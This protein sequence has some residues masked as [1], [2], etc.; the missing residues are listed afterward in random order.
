M[1][2]L[3]FKSEGNKT[4]ISEEK[5]THQLVSRLLQVEPDKLVSALT[6]RELRIKGQNTTYVNLA[7]KDA[8]DTRD[9]LAK[10]MYIF[11]LVAFEHVT[12]HSHSHVIG[13]EQCSTGW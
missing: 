7:Q 11:L 2:N 9:A 8:S 1:G 12:I 5:K 4:T 13:T 6:I 3:Q 10:F